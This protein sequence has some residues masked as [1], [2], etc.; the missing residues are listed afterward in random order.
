MDSDNLPGT[1]W[2]G[3][4]E[5]DNV[6]EIFDSF[7]MVLPPLLQAWAARNSKKWTHG[8]LLIQHPLAVTCG[9]YAYIFTLTRP[10]FDN[11]NDTVHY[12]DSLCI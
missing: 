6:I 11:L 1:H 4:Y 12:I 10:Y 8:K 2:V 5:N 9:Y 3:I 7:G